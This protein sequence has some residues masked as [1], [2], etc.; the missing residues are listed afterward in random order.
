MHGIRAHTTLCPFIAVQAR[1]RGILPFCLINKEA[2]VCQEKSKWTRNSL[3]SRN[4][5]EPPRLA[6]NQTDFAA[7]AGRKR[8]IGR[9]PGL[10]GQAICR[11]S[12][13]NIPAKQASSQQIR[14]KDVGLGHEIRHLEIPLTE[15]HGRG[16]T[17]A[18]RH[19][20]RLPG[21]SSYRECPHGQSFSSCCHA[22]S[23]NDDKLKLRIWMRTSCCA[24]VPL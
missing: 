3:D 12:S 13:M 23:M 6:R 16:K 2:S 18:Q 5:D 22:T 17:L 21:R 24:L 10:F 4:Q 1:L 15:A 14:R 20:L 19:M 11:V 8:W 7:I 9:C